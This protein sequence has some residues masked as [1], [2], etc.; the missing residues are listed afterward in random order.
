LEQIKNDVAYSDNPVK[1]IGI[2]AG[3]SYGALGTTHHSLHDYAVLRAINNITIIAPADNYE[4]A[5]AIKLAA[6]MET[7]VYLRFG[8]KN[9]PDLKAVD[10]APFRFGKGRIIRQGNDI[11]FIATGETV[12]PAWKAAEKL[13]QDYGIYATVISMHTV[14]PLDYALLEATGNK[15]NTIITVEEHSVFG[16]LGEACASFLLQHRNFSTG[17]TWKG[18]FKIIGIPDEYTVTGS[19]NEIFDHYGISES[20][21]TA[22]AV[23]MTRKVK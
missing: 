7:P 10:D 9:M 12:Y 8:K 22:T 13:E 3:V 18:A 19:Q 5:E 23:E 14:K 21:L 17:G 2:S 15:C 4:T 16:G 20:G 1:L 11:A 6:A